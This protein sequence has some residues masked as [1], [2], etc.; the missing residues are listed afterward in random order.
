MDGE[1]IRFDGPGRYVITTKGEVNPDIFELY[2][3]KKNKSSVTGG[4]LTG[5]ELIVEIK[6]Q[7]ELLSLLN[8][9]YDNHIAIIK[10]ELLSN[11]ISKQAHPEQEKSQESKLYEE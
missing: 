1:D 4:G 8:I 3:A 9:L 11:R 2:N 6:D 7:S 5:S 10:V